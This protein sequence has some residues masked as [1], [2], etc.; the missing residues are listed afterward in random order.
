MSEPK[1]IGYGPGRRLFAAGTVCP[2][3]EDK[4]RQ[5]E[6]GAADVNQIVKKFSFEALNAEFEARLDRGE[7]PWIG[8]DTT[9]V[10]NEYRQALDQV[11]RTTEY[12]LRLPPE[13]RFKFNNDPAQMLDDYAAGRQREVFEEIGVL[14]K[15]A[16]EAAVPVTGNPATGQGQNPPA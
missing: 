13:I 5:S 3:E 8:V 14:E 16:P 15:A 10:P 2:P 12:F 6:K 11:N 4:A 9:I 7:A 1:D